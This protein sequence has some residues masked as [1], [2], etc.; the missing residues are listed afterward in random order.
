[1]D[2]FVNQL[3]QFYS[4]LTRQIF[5][6]TQYDVLTYKMAIALRPQIRDVTSPYTAFDLSD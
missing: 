4:N 5:N 1:M 3:I 2:I 6:S